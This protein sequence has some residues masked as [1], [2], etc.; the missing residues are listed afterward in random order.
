[1][2]APDCG[3]GKGFLG[4]LC[5]AGTTEISERADHCESVPVRKVRHFERPKSRF[6]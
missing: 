2:I 3:G 5:V 1:M 4:P 6:R